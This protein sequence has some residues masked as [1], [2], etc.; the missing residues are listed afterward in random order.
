M[1]LRKRNV[2]LMAIVIL[3]TEKEVCDTLK[4]LVPCTLKLTGFNEHQQQRPLV[5]IKSLSI[6][7]IQEK[8]FICK[9]QVGCQ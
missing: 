9:L 4:E 2:D 3:T 1:N 6:L 5:S 7:F 8:H